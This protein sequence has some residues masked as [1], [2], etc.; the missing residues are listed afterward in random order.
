MSVYSYQNRLLVVGFFLSKGVCDR[1]KIKGLNTMAELIKVSDFNGGDSD[2]GIRV[3]KEALVNGPSKFLRE[4]MADGLEATLNRMSK[5]LVA[6]LFGGIILWR[7][8]SE[9]LWASMGSLLNCILSIVLK[10]ILNQERPVSTLRSDPGMPSSHAQF[11]FFTVMFTNLSIME[12]LGTNI[13]TVTISGLALAFGSYLSW[14]RVS[15][16]FHTVS[17]VVVGAALGSIFCILWSW[18]WNAYVLK[19]FISILWVR[20][21]VVLGAAGFAWIFLYMW[22]VF[23]LGMRRNSLDKLMKAKLHSILV[24]IR[25]KS[26]LRSLNRWT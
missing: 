12:W 3:R 4:F 11:I 21:V 22:F 5:W 13:F 15:Q 20:I 24:K 18:S 16:R 1:N 26:M 19:V 6:A 23:R 14:L 10:W 9:V 7:H 2:E 17:Q 8:D 25:R